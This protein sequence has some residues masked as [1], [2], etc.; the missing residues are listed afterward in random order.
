MAENQLAQQTDAAQPETQP[1]GMEEHCRRV[2]AW[3]SELAR[4][5]E[6]TSEESAAL[7]GAALMHH[8]PDLQQHLAAPKLLAEMGLDVSN[9]YTDSADPGPELSSKVLDAFNGTLPNGEPARVLELAGILEAA[10]SLDEQLEFAPFANED[11]QPVVQGVLQGRAPENEVGAAVQK[12]RYCSR[13]ELAEGIGRLPDYPATAMK[14]HQLLA[15]HNV[16]LRSLETIARTDQVIAAR[17]IAVSNSA[18]YSRKESIRHLCQAISFIGFAEARRVLLSVAIEP[19]FNE[20]KHG[21]LWKHS[22][23]TAQVAEQIAELVGNV[24][25]AEA[26]LLGLLHDVGKLAISML[27]REVTDAIDRLV[28]L[29]CQPAMAELVFCGFDH[30]EAGAEVLRAWNFSEEHVTAVRYHHQPERSMSPLAAVLYLTEFWTDSEEDLPSNARLCAALRITS[31]T[32][33]VLDSALGTLHN[34]LPC[35]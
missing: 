1:A 27:P 3:C 32:P 8:R 5:F 26:F 33:A 13:V 21:Q 18:L 9:A 16:N 35:E 23:E 12:L 31:L 19:L 20:A 28:Q 10:N 24:D 7:T 6:L 25:P 29:G 14:M 4:A 34:V 17:L 30:A 11:F 22:L 2:A 15:D